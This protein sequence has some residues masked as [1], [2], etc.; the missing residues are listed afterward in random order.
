M[1]TFLPSPNFTTSAKFLDPQRLGKQRSEAM[2]I[3]TALTN[4]AYGW[5]NHPAIAMWRDSKMMLV[6]YTRAICE[7]WIARGYKDTCL[8]KTI[9]LWKA[10]IKDMEAQELVEFCGGSPSWLTTEFCSNHRSILLA[11]NPEWYGQFGWMEV[12][13]VRNAKGQWPYLWPKL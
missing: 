9:A 11:K 8:D 5:Q 4:P 12:P 1:Q 6:F 13:A 2:Q 10:A 7:E 3:L